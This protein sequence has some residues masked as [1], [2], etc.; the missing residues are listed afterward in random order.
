MG[1]IYRPPNQ[2]NFIDYFNNALGKIPFQSN[3]IYLLGHFN[4]DLFFEG[5]YVQ[6]KSFKRLKEAQL[7]HRLLK[8]YVETFI[9]FRLNQ[10]IEKAK[11]LPLYTVSLIAHILTNSKENVRNY[12]VISNAIS[13]HDLFYCTRKTE[14]VNT[15]KHNIKSI[16]SYRKYY[17]K[18]LQERLG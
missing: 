9:A 6:R 13:D 14:T 17:K 1:I 18:S 3:K 5:H 2:V 11:N 8:L 15:R 7:K 12:G 4:I 10:L 16:R